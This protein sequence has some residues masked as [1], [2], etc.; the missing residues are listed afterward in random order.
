M[1]QNIGTPVYSAPEV[2]TSS[3]YTEKCDL[4]SY[5]VILCEL[6]SGRQVYSEPEFTQMKIGTLLYKICNSGLRPQI[7]VFLP[8]I[9]KN[10]ISECLDADPDLR[11]NFSEVV[12]RFHRLR[13]TM[14]QHGPEEVGRH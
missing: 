7:P 3:I 2:L 14:S 4:Y 8:L 13:K 5:G 11:P 10:T 9:I 6:F 12:A 1:T